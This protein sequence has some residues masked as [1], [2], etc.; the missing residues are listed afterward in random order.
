VD[1]GL[2]LW[3]NENSNVIETG[4]LGQKGEIRQVSSGCIMKARIKEIERLY[5]KLLHINEGGSGL[6]KIDSKVRSE[7]FTRI[8]KGVERLRDEQESHPSWSKDYWDIDREIRRLLLKEIQIIIDDYV[9]AKGAG[10]LSRWEDMYGD[11]DYYK[12]IFFNLRM[13]S[14]YDRRRKK[15]QGM[16]FV[17]GRWERVEFVKIE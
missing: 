9:V 17:K 7:I 2:F 11:I 3:H 4:I 10:H 16:K 15:A 5:K 12:D 1:L 14:A 8:I 13:D 6:Y